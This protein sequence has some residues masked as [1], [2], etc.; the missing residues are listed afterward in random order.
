MTKLNGLGSL[1]TFARSPSGMLS[2]E[3]VAISEK[4][5]AGVDSTVV[6]EDD[7]DDFLPASHC[8][9]GS[10]GSHGLHGSHG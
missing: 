10:H 6:V 2:R 1:P 3:E 5:V 9:H 7:W 8:S 4:A